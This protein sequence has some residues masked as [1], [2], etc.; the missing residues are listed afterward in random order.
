MRL[1]LAREGDPGALIEIQLH[2]DGRH[3]DGAPGDGVFAADLPEFAERG[4][5]DDARGTLRILAS[6]A[7]MGTES[8]RREAAAPWILR[9][10]GARALAAS[11]PLDLGTH[12]S[13]SD[14]RGLVALRL[15]GP[16]GALQAELLPAP[17]GEGLLAPPAPPRLDGVPASLEPRQPAELSLSLALPEGLAPGRY[18]GTL[19]LRVA[20]AGREPVAAEVPWRVEVRAPELRAEP[21]DLGALWPGQRALKTLRLAT[22]GG[23]T[24]LL[25]FELRANKPSPFPSPSRRERGYMCTNFC[26]P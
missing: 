6:G 26:P 3:G 25:P 21:L 7:R 15:R 10:S 14:A 18:G 2:D 22:R 16:G 24:R 17:E 8:F 12:W 19:R 5:P 11:G 4:W 9:R 13:G 20:G 23:R 1:E